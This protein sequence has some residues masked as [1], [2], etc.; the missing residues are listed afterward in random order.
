[1]AVNNSTSG[2]LWLYHT[3][4]PAGKPK[5]VVRKKTSGEFALT[6]SVGGKNIGCVSYQHNF[7]SS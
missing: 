6:F 5:Q 1:M 2:E 7:S 4:W 3:F